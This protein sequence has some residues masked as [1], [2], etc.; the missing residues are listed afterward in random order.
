MKFRSGLII[1]FSLG[2][3]FGSKAGRERYRQ[4]NALLERVRSEPRVEQATT[5]AREVIDQG[6]QAARS[7]VVDIR[8]KAADEASQKVGDLMGEH[9]HDGQ[10]V[11]APDVDPTVTRV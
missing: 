9:D 1:G 7:A 8:N 3:Y 4:L 6:T 2:Y 11:D 5:R 10:Y